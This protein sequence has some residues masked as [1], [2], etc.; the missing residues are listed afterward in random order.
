MR[1]CVEARAEAGRGLLGDRTAERGSAKRQV[2]LLQ[3]EHLGVLASL[4]GRESVEAE[5]LRRNLIVSGINLLALRNRLFMI[6]DVLLEGTGPCDPC[7]RMEAA[8]GPGGLNAM[9]GHGGITARVLQSGDIRVGHPVRIHPASP[10]T[11]SGGTAG[12]SEDPA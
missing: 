12:N 4:C 6:G 8:L 9:R 10:V 3:F 5:L 7:S 2:T 11:G 1:T